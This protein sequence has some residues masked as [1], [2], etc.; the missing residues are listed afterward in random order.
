MPYQVTWRPNALEQ[1]ADLVEKVAL[2]N[3]SAAQSLYD[4]LW[5]APNPLTVRAE[6]ELSHRAD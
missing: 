5:K 3:T 2:H 6:V 4:D 1:L